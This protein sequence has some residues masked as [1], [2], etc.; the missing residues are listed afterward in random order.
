MRYLITGVTGFAGSHLADYLLEHEPDG[1]VFGTIRWRSRTEN[2]D[3]L[4]DRLQLI[5]ADLHDSSS[6]RRVL[7]IARPDR[8]FHLAAQSYVP[9]S[10][11]VPAETLDANITGQLN[12]FEAI[13]ALR[14]EPRIQIA[15][16][17]EEYG[18]VYEHELPIREDNPLRP[19]SPYAVSKVAQDF[20]AYQ[21]FK[22]YGLWVVRT[23]GFNH[24]GPRRGEVFVCSNFSKQVVEIESG[25]RPPVVD[26]GNL[27]SRRDFTDVRDM[28]RGYVMALEHCEPGEVYN[29]CSGHA[30]AAGELLDLLSRHTGLEF[31]TRQ[32]PGRL[33]P[34][35]VPV[36]IGDSTRFRK[37]SGWEP[38]I[39]F[40]QTLGDLVAYWRRR[41]G[42]GAA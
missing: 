24:T 7:E 12:L 5:E 27:E 29:L 1:Q 6:L 35:D 21:Y 3:H 14:L 42:S 33:R 23:R 25:R 36:L 22:S 20:L 9:A 19:L 26:V 11:T 32:D 17:S 13:R 41:L 31:E 10:W 28:V 16:S 39:A 40:E 8:I 37:A 2:I 30:Y 38:Q 18:M 4:R 15:C 34:S